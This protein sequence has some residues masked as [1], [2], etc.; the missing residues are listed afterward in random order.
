MTRY[1]Y[2]AGIDHTWPNSLKKMTDESAHNQSEGAY[3]MIDILDVRCQN[4]SYS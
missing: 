1:N 2:K 3:Y 4:V